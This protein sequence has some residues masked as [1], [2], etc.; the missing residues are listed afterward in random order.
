M[1]NT[2]LMIVASVA[3][4]AVASA[5]ALWQAAADPGSMYAPQPEKLMVWKKH[6]LV[7]VRIEERSNVTRLDALETTRESELSFALDELI[8]I[9]GRG[10]LTPG[11]P[12][13]GIE[14]DASFEATNE[15]QRRRRSTF[16]DTLMAEVVEVLPGYDP[17]ENDG[18]LVIRGHKSIKIMD[19]HERVAITGRI[20]TKDI[21]ADR[22]IDASRV[23]EADIQLSG[24]GDVSSAAEQGWLT[25][26][27]NTLWPF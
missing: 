25:K 20:S 6:D 8:R 16:S 27:L 21:R 9:G 26:M 11:F 22:S 7:L 2:V 24:T 1:R 17:E 13:L 18:L 23:F 15:G 10:R 3:L 19:D 4:S 14:A 12:D 5:Q